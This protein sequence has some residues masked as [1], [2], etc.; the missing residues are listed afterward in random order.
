MSPLDFLLIASVAIYPLLLALEHLVPARWQPALPAWRTLGA[1]FFVAFSVLSYTLPQALP[2]AWFEATSLLPG[3]SL[4]VAGGTVAGY[5]AVSLV[6]YGWHR[7]VHASPLLWR[8]FH[9][10]H[11]APKRL[12]VSSA[13]IFH[14]SEMVFYILMPL[15]VT[16]LVLGLDPVAAGL[17]GLISTFN[18]LF[19]HANIATPRWLTWFAQRPEAHSIH[20]AEHAHNY[21]DFP[22][23][24]RL[25]GTYREGVGFRREVGFASEASRRW[26]AMAMCR[27]VSSTATPARPGSTAQA[28]AQA[29]ARA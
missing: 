5:L 12:D 7:A 23:W 26:W 21:G 29:R 19:Q 24:D 14:P 28:Q 16:T 1:L 10:A 20:H 9:Q 6:G 3:A 25:F 8:L 15:A 13:A 18:A 27:D 4:G 11:H 22:L 2:A 17:V